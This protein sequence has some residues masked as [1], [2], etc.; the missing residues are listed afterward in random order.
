MENRPIGPPDNQRAMHKTLRRENKATFCKQ[1]PFIIQPDFYLPRQVVGIIC[2]GPYEGNNLIAI[3]DMGLRRYSVG[4]FPI[5][6]TIYC[7]RTRYNAIT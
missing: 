7:E 1:I 2:I 5:P 4:A 6:H 3:V